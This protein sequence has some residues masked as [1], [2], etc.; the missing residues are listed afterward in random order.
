RSPDFLTPP[1]EG[2]RATIGDLPHRVALF[3]FFTGQP[4]V[5]AAGNAILDP[6]FKGNRIGAI[7]DY[8]DRQGDA[9]ILSRPH[10]SV[11]DG[12]EAT[13]ENTEQ[14]A[15]Q[16]AAILQN[17]VFNI[18][19]PQGGAL[20][21]RVPTGTQFIEVGTILK[22]TPR[23]NEED[24]IILE[25]EAEDSDAEDKTVVTAGLPST[26]PEKRQRRT[27][28]KVIIHDRQTIV[29]G[30]LGSTNLSDN[31]DKVP[32][33]GDIPVLG[34][35]F[36]STQKE[37]TERELLVF[38]TP[39]IV[40]EYTQPVASKLAK[41]ENELSREMRHSTKGLMGRVHD[42]LS[43]GGNTIMISVGEIGQ[44]Y[45]E[46]EEAQLDDLYEILASVTTPTQTTL[47]MRNDPAAPASVTTA[48]NE[49]VMN[50][51]FKVEFDEG[52][53]PIVPVKRTEL[54]YVTTPGR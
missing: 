35:L 46:G 19:N 34:R 1:N 54:E 18:N 42:R 20:Q 31:V 6:E 9:Q 50:M 5:D 26:I 16:E 43:K 17:S 28:T 25:I 11:L 2:E 37:R 21:N 41:Y 8:L 10:V 24:N 38:I 15:Y 45:V 27:E 4:L 12:G 52:L 47:V 23:I 7:L 44:I 51:Q 29:I 3:D 22:V 49:M 13:F 40:D 53:P 32:F 48:V 30:G 36:K 39:T 33:L 14:R